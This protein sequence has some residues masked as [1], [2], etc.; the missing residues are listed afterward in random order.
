MVNK[1]WLETTVIDPFDITK[2]SK[3]AKDG[4]QNWTMTTLVK[5]NEKFCR[6]IVQARFLEVNFTVVLRTIRHLRLTSW[7]RWFP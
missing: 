7:T 4:R 2:G 1:H 5:L 6:S 3:Q